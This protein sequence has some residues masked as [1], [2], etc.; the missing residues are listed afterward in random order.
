MAKFAKLFEIGNEQLL[1][2]LERNDDG[3]PQVSC[4]TETELG[5][6]S[7]SPGFIPH[8]SQMS[9]TINHLLLQKSILIQLISQWLR[10]FLPIFTRALVS[11]W[12]RKF[13]RFHGQ[14]VVLTIKKV[15][16]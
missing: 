6:L 5:E 7:L 8:E 1:V 2:K 13:F 11:L 15:K 10:R 4:T 16:I 12:I 9:H 3:Y 14:R